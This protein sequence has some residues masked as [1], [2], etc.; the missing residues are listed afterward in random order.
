MA[1]LDRI[2]NPI[3]NTLANIDAGRG[4][5]DTIIARY[6]S[7]IETTDDPFVLFTKHKASYNERGNSS[8]VELTPMGHVSLYMPMGFAINDQA[9]FET[10]ATG[11]LGA[12]A[13]ALL[14]GVNPVTSGTQAD[15]AAIGM[16]LSNQIGSA[17]GGGVGSLV[18]G[19]VGGLVGAIT[20]AVGL[21]NV[22]Q[23]TAQEFNKQAQLSVNPR[24]FMLYKS[25]GMRNF[26]FRFRFIPDSEAESRSAEQI[27]AWFRRGMYPTIAGR[28]SFNFPD[29]FEIQV[30]NMEGLPKLPEVFLESASVTYNPN[31]M[32]Y[33]K[34]GNRPVE[35]NLSLEFKE[36]QPIT[37]ESI[38]EGF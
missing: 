13:N 17:V 29:A 32:S 2:I 18:P 14:N 7:N 35:I 33:F 20:G 36:L 25:P 34:Q 1:I 15:V 11:I 5:S 30:K 26:S 22:A 37:R 24:E 27:V 23:A 4:P 16:S 31:S 8:R 10:A 6:P 21:G 12:G 28:Y 9:V 19:R 3:R 38:N